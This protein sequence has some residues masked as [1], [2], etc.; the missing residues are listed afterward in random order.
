MAAAVSPSSCSTASPP[1]KLNRYDPWRLSCSVCVCLSYAFASFCRYDFS[2]VELPGTCCGTRLVNQFP[3]SISK[4]L[5]IMLKGAWSTDMSSRGYKQ[6]A[7]DDVSLGQGERFPLPTHRQFCSCATSP[8]AIACP[9]CQL[10]MYRNGTRSLR[11][12]TPVSPRPTPLND[13][14]PRITPHATPFHDT[15]HAPPPLRSSM[16]LLPPLPSPVGATYIGRLPGELYCT[17]PAQRRVQGAR[18]V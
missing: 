11:E 17:V 1:P 16:P 12:P 13:T 8:Q 10:S 3:D 18:P 5:A 14:T 7:T 15:P 6:L 2:Q 4:N 9:C